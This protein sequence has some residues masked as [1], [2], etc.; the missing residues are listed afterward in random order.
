MPPKLVDISTNKSALVQI[1][2]Y[3][4]YLITKATIIIGPIS[5]CMKQPWLCQKVRQGQRVHGS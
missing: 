3:I 1:I 4:L 5:G 2:G